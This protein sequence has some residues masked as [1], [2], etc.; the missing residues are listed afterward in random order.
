NVVDVTN[1]VLMECAQP[2]HAFDF[3]KLH[4]RRIVVRRARK[5]E[6]I[7]AIDQ[8]TYELSPET[9]VIADA[10]R[11]VAIGGV[12]GGLDTE[13][14]NRTTN[15][16]IETADFAPMSIRATARALNLHSDSSFRFERGIDRA[17][18][19]W[20]SR[21]CCQLILDVAGGELLDD[22]C[23]AGTLTAAPP[24][25]IR[26]RFPQIARLL[27]IDVPEARAASI[28]QALGLQQRGGPKKGTAEFVPPSWRRDLIREVDLIEEVARIHGY[29]HIPDNVTV[30][31]EL[32]RRTERD[33]VTAKVRELLTAARFFEAV[34]MSFVSDKTRRHF[35]PRGDRPPLSVDHSSRRHEN[36]L[37]QSL[38]PSLL[39]SR[40]ENERHGVFNAD[41]FEIAKVYLEAGPG[42]PERD[43]EP[44]V[45]GIVGGR[46]FAAMKGIVTALAR[47]I[48][49]KSAVTVRPSTVAQFAEGRGAEVW[50]DGRSWGWLG[51]LDRNVADELDLR[52]AVVAAELDLA[53]LED[54]ADLTP[55]YSP[56]PNFPAVERDLNF[57]LDEAVTWQ[58]LEEVVQGAGGELLE[59]IA[60]GG[61]YRGKQIDA[62]KKSY[63]VTLS[64]RSTE[65]TLTSDEV[66]SAQNAV[67]EA[68]R[69]KLG[70]TLRA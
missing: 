46:D 56:L 34:T 1:Y 51:E 24:A 69:Q 68:G 57:L 59:A 65:R 67:V 33:R 44:T 54:V 21:R 49:G 58:E 12:M 61:Q 38:V 29:H 4:E 63:V 5:G 19:D 3:D 28:L 39:E 55:V 7:V 27:G 53:V 42:K 66:D 62:G 32:S 10:D 35:M 15:V 48:A 13:I 18:L 22:R 37:R 47:A 31:L 70:A 11:P 45:I 9:C 2:L 17:G 60:F 43:V 6:K 41:L 50:L 25:P 40:R 52:D 30:P 8:R 64:F 16:L 36:L 26:L 20:A 14:G 23:V